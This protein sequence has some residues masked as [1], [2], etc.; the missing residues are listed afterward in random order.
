MDLERITL[1]C[2]VSRSARVVQ[3]QFAVFLPIVGKSLRGRDFRQINSKNGLNCRPM[4]ADFRCGGLDGPN[5]LAERQV[6]DYTGLKEPHPGPGGAWGG[7]KPGGRF[8]CG[9]TGWD[10]PFL[11]RRKTR[12]IAR[13]GHFTV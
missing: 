2:I 7:E 12:K 4:G 5:R 3:D 8:F 1:S 6:V 11:H 13:D 9:G 10:G